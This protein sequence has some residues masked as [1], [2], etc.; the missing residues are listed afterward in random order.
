MKP[1]LLAGVLRLVCAVILLGLGACGSL[2]PKPAPPP[3]LHLLTWDSAARALPSLA[4]LPSLKIAPVQASLRI[5]PPQAAAGFDSRRIIYLREPYRLDYFAKHEWA[6][7]PARMLAPLLLAA[8][9][10]GGGFR[11][12]F[13]APSAAAADFSLDTE[14]IRLQQDFSHIPSQLRLTLRASLL[15]N[16]T[17][18]VLASRE[19]DVREAAP[20]EDAAG[21]VIAANQALQKLLADLVRAPGF[22]P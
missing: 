1:N 20:S 9:E 2:L 15:D 21:G 12:V 8:F 11:A 10:A 16:A 14:L 6:D 3:T 4:S 17:R 22:T 5:N 7:T 13:A 18:R 19:F